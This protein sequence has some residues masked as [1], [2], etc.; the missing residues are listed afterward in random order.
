MLA[1]RINT[2]RTAMSPRFL[3]GLLL[4]F[5]VGFHSVS[6][7]CTNREPT[8]AVGFSPHWHYDSN[9][10]SSTELW[11]EGDPGEPLFLRGRV[12]DTCG[13]AVA[14]ARVQLW[15]ADK[16]GTHADDRWR[17]D[18]RVADDGSFKLKTVLPGYAGGL[19][20]HIHIVVSHGG[21]QELVTR[22]FF[23]DDEYLA[24]S[25]QDL[26]LLLEEIQR[27]SGR[28]WVTGFEFVLKPGE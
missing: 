9:A 1:R 18:F 6:I 11:R 7:A 16:D 17:T 12:L 8:R 14:G 3:S 23:R 2:M 24:A 21:H 5:L 19:P 25:D 27:D 10:P 15:H 22:L 20:R 28:G 26:A 4:F 13:K